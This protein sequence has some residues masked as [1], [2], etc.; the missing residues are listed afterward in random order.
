MRLSFKQ[1]IDGSNPSKTW[2]IF[3]AYKLAET[4]QVEETFKLPFSNYQLEVKSFQSQLLRKYFKPEVFT[5]GDW[6]KSSQPKPLT[7]RRDAT[8]TRNFAELSCRLTHNHHQVKGGK[9]SQNKSRIKATKQKQCISNPQND[10]LKKLKNR[11]R[12][13]WLH[14]NKL[15]FFS[16]ESCQGFVA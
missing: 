4:P 12:Y 6:C 7:K 15:T 5:T 3:R 10:N 2:K 11:K 16:R 14:K 13:R 8:L 1:E 9:I